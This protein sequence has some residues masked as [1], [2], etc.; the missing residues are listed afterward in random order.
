[1]HRTVRFWGV[2]WATLML[3]GMAFS[4]TQ[5]AT[6]S[7]RITDQ[8]GGVV[9]GAS[10]EV[11][12]NDTNLTVRAESNTAGLYFAPYLIPGSYRIVI[13]KPGL[14]EIVKTGLTLHVQDAVEQNFQL[15]VGSIAQSVQV[16]GEA[17]LVNTENASLGQIVDNKR[18][19]DLPMNGRS[20][21]GSSFSLPMFTRTRDR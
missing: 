9:P 14:A 13:R 12:N 2:L 1:M 7:G 21:F 11:I 8:Q 19:Q 20:A 5:P 18:I 17:P 15:R 3:A 16:T 10:V 6:L 4:Q